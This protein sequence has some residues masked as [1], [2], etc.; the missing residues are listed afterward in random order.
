MI[1]HIVKRGETI[2][3]IARNYGIDEEILIRENGVF[4]RESLVIGEALVIIY[5]KQIHIIQAGETLEGIAATYGITVLEILRNNPYLSDRKYIYPGEKIIIQY[6]DLK[7]KKIATNG[8]TYTFVDENILKKTLPY[9]T[10]LTVIGNIVTEEGG[11]LSVDDRDIVELAGLYGVA[12]IMMLTA[13]GNNQSEKIETTHIILSDQEIQEQ[14]LS[15]ILFVLEEKGYAGINVDSPYIYPQDRENYMNFIEKLNIRLKSKGYKLFSTFGISVFDVMSGIFFQDFDY[16]KLSQAVDG[17]I[18]TAYEGG[19]EVGVPTGMLAF[20]T[21][22]NFLEKLVGYISSDKIS[23]G[24]LNVGYLWQLPYIPGISKGQSISYQSA[25]QLASDQGAKIMFDDTTKASYFQYV[26]I[27]DY[28][29]R[30]WD[31]RAIDAY[32]KLVLVYELQG[33]TNNNISNFFY[34]MWLI[35]NTQYDI[36][37]IF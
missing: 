7:I 30:F 10:Y 6:K 25:I 11:V 1:I 32:L 20:D 37:K 36:E 15:N 28:I 18:F 33:V 17:V 22:L 26:E 2:S 23:I 12:P 9:L 5:P 8:A 16:S 14:L 3:S 29:V 24:L 34:Q 19:Y 31:A 4:N 27:Y 21:V 35:I 13:F